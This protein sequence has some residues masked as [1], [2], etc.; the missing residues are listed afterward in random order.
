MNLD[1]ISKIKLIIQEKFQ[2]SENISYICAGINRNTLNIQNFYS[3]KKMKLS[4]IKSYTLT[5]A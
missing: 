5:P 2:R 1:L 4:F 3:I